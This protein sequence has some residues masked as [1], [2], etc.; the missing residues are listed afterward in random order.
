MRPLSTP[1]RLYTSTRLHVYAWH[2]LTRA[3]PWRERREAV[4]VL[5]FH[6]A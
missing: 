3:W 2:R 1:L 6:A 5:C 4:K